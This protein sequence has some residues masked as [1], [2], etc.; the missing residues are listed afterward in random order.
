ML[1]ISIRKKILFSFI[2]INAL[3]L[4]IKKKIKIKILSNIKCEIFVYKYYGFF[5][6]KAITDKI[7]QVLSQCKHDLLN[8]SRD[9]V[10]KKNVRIIK[11]KERMA[12]YLR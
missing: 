7:K 5:F 11:E 4:F 10:I 9:F 2:I 8:L 3:D 1:K 6:V 12:K